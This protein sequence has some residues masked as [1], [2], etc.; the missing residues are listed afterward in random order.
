MIERTDPIVKADNKSTD[1][2][3]QAR[4]RIGVRVPLNP[5]ISGFLLGTYLCALVIYLDYDPLVV[6]LFVISWVIIPFLALSDHIV[7]DGRRISRTGLVSIVTSRLTGGRRSLRV[8]DVEQ[9]DTQAVRLIRRSGRIL[10]RYRTAIKGRGLEFVLTSTGENYRRM[11]QAILPFVPEDALDTRSLDLRDHL[12]DPKEVQMKASFAGIPR[13]EVL[14]HT[15]MS[16]PG[17]NKAVPERELDISPEEGDRADYLHQLGNELRLAGYLTQALESFRRALIL[18]PHDGRLIFD[19]ARCLQSFAGAER[20]PDLDLR[21][22]AALRLAERYCGDDAAL[23]SRIGESYAQYGRWDRAVR[24]F[25]KAIDR[26]GE[27]FLAARGLAETALREGKIAHVIHQFMAAHRAASTPSLRRWTRVE[28]DYF[29]NLNNDAEYMDLELGRVKLIDSLFRTRR[30]VLVAAMVGMLPLM[31]GLI[32]DD[33]ILVDVG[34]AITGISLAA[35]TV[36]QLISRTL[37]NRIPY[38]VMPDSE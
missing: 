9:I 26:A 16:R 34:W 15:I 18:K 1:R 31:L 24:S 3:S 14:S 37:T 27:T 4:S 20:Q 21:S 10:Y 22:I 6:P 17:R 25:Q 35:W 5:Y 32:A 36:C 30:T 38:D 12:A 33:H 29:S 28:A 23:L 13:A 19:F 2:A 7:F 11:M 8:S